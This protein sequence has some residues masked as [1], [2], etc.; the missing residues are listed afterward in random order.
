MGM[1]IYSRGGGDLRRRGGLGLHRN[2]HPKEWGKT[3]W[4]VYTKY[5]RFRVKSEWGHNTVAAVQQI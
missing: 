1:F 5:I 4:W 2:G 3:N